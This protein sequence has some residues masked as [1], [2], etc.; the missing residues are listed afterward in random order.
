MIKLHTILKQFYPEA[1]LL[2]YTPIGNGHINQT[3]LA[4]FQA[5]NQTQQTVLQQI[6]TNVFRNPEAIMN[7]I[8]LVGEH[9]QSTNYPYE[10]LMPLLT[11]QQKFGLWHEHEYWRAYPYLPNVTEV[12]KAPTEKEA[13]DIAKCYGHFAHYLDGIDLQKIQITIPDFH[14]SILR[15][16]QFEEA[17]HNN[18][19]S[20][21]QQH[22]IESILPLQKIAIEA[23]QAIQELPARVI[24]SDTKMNNVLVNQKTMRPIAVA[25]LDTLMPGCIL[26][27]FG[28]M[29]RT[30][31]NST[32][33]DCHQ[34]EQITMR[35]PIF[36]ALATGFLEGCGEI[37]TTEEKQHFILGALN[38]VLMQAVR[39]LTD[40][41]NGN[42][43]YKI[44][45]PEHNLDRA[46][47]QLALL[48]S[49][50]K[51]RKAMQEI[52]KQM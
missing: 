13:Y 24:H 40:S 15:W 3:L 26:S 36:Q 12:E 5:D 18:Q 25:D 6:N 51:Q 8:V 20:V 27:D 42:L 10:I 28:D 44:K 46:I 23:D 30:L 37:L 19:T 11:L 14:N 31:T 33:E 38:V 17:I 35:M 34:T 9:L 43:Y 16:K 29:V 1:Q 45:Y 47:N 2:S 21:K 4:Q 32:D 39:F 48:Q 41:L 52:L 49:M 22:L 50:L 7:N